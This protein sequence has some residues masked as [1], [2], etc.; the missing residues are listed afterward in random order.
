[1]TEDPAAVIAAIEARAQRYETPCGE[2]NM[3]WRSWGRGE[4][5]V[6]LHGGSGSWKHW[7]RNIE[8][9]AATR[10]VIAA[11]MPGY[12]D[13]ALPPQPT[14]FSAL[15]EI[16]AR[17]LDEII[18]AG[19]VYDVVG[20]SLGSFMAP[21]IALGTQARARKL[22][23]IHGHFVG[24]MAYSPQDRLKRWRGV[25]DR[26]ERDLILRHNLGALMLAHPDSADDL[27]LEVYR[28]DLEKSRL[29]VPTF[30][31]SLDTSILTRVDARLYAIT[32]AADPIR[33]PSVEAQQRALLRLRPDARC[34]IIPGAGH[35][36]MW[37]S[38][39]AFLTIADAI[40][41]ED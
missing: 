20:F 38:A 8:H 39:P 2:G 32:G 7:L 36:V 27:T 26:A 35:W 6:L 15:G 24:R 16:M 31:E 23:L 30:I 1:M 9:F 41:H 13:S 37:E 18:G 34:W 40:L 33:S 11:D 4:P 28:S 19:A 5:L 12:G 17:G 21:W 29:R 14:G 3:V 22:V 10:R 25:E